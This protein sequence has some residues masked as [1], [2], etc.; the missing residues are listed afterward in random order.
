[1]KRASE[2]N[3]TT[4]KRARAILEEPVAQLLASPCCHLQCLHELS[5]N[6]ILP[7]R[8][9]YAQLSEK[10]RRELLWKAVTYGQLSRNV[11][12][13]KQVNQVHLILLQFHFDMFLCTN[14][15]HVVTGAGHCRIREY[16]RLKWKGVLDSDILGSTTRSAT[17]ESLPREHLHAYLRQ[18]VKDLGDNDPVDGTIHMPMGFSLETVHKMYCEDT[19]TKEYFLLHSLGDP[20]SLSTLR[21]IWNEDFSHLK[22]PRHTRLGKCDECFTITKKIQD[23]SFTLEVR[24]AYK[25]KL[26]AH[27]KLVRDERRLYEDCRTSSQ[28]NLN[29]VLSIIFD[30]ARPVGF[31]NLTPT[32]KMFGDLSRLLLPVYG[33]KCHTFKSHRLIVSPPHVHH[34][35]NFVITTLVLL[36]GDLYQQHQSQF[37]RKRLVL[38]ADN[39]T[40]QNKNS[41]LVGFLALLV[42]IG[43]FEVVEL[44]FLPVGHTHEVSAKNS[45]LP[46]V[47][48]T[49]PQDIDAMFGNF[50]NICQTTF[51]DCYTFDEMKSACGLHGK[52]SFKPWE[53]VFL[54]TILDWKQYLGVDNRTPALKHIT[55][56]HAFMLGKAQNGEV[57]LL[58]KEWRRDPEW[59]GSF[60]N[61]S[62][63]TIIETD[64]VPT[65]LQ[66]LPKYVHHKEVD[67]AVPDTVCALVQAIQNSGAG[68]PSRIAWYQQFLK[69]NPA[70]AELPDVLRKILLHIPLPDNLISPPI[71]QP[72]PA[73]AQPIIKQ[74][75]RVDPALYAGRIPKPDELVVV[76]MNPDDRRKWP[77]YYFWVARVLPDQ[78]QSK[79][80]TVKILWL[81]CHNGVYTEAARKSE[82]IWNV[83]KETIL[84]SGFDLTAKKTFYLAFERIVKEHEK[85]QQFL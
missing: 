74:A 44:Y 19:D 55:Q 4:S 76:E 12:Y 73:P 83:K 50:S 68:S 58:F 15:L 21:R 56:H 41:Y 69:V 29:G 40:S 84:F 39:T 16:M 70:P 8:K 5:V 31:P 47:S 35:V 9:Y 34:D 37:P 80:G 61:S 65:V 3:I 11:T 59:S 1:M 20:V 45:L 25:A 51:N 77:N 48:L 66:Q 62:G 7:I 60:Q 42:S 46:V 26:Q 22:L 23:K 64:R 24:E 38:Q 10:E 36:L 53:M 54:E 33:A 52:L 79:Q 63:L 30:G 32:P 17:K 72:N 78:Q 13:L 28:G 2:V 49:K 67:P 57:Q 81:K 18:L 82:N 85:V 75:L 27:H 43:L 6:K 14:A 71:P